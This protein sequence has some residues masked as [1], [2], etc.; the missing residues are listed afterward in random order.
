MPKDKDLMRDT[1]KSFKHKDLQKPSRKDRKKHKFIDERD[2]DLKDTKRDPDL[3]LAK[4]LINI[5]KQLI[6]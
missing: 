6:G 5:A 2:P 4:Q 1:G 3:K